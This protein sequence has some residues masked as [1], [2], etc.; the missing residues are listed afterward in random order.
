[1]GRKGEGMTTNEK[2][3][4]DKFENL[5][6]RIEKENF[7]ADE[8]II[9]HRMIDLWKAFEIFGRVANTSR[10]IIIWVAAIIVLWAMPFDNIMKALRKFFGFG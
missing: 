8:L 10:T 2:K 4:L 1:M 3:A 6:D 5:I 7:S 9:L